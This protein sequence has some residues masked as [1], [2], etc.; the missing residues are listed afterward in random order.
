MFV[1]YPQA[2]PAQ[3]VTADSIDECVKDFV[4]EILLSVILSCVLCLITKKR[5]FIREQFF[6]TYNN[7]WLVKEVDVPNDSN[8]ILTDTVFKISIF[9]Q[10]HIKKLFSTFNLQ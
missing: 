1:I 8:H 3:Y 6:I 5:K 2:A 4:R 9:L 10:F 7:K